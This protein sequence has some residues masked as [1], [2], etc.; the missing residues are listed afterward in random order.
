[1]TNSVRISDINLRINTQNI[2]TTTDIGELRKEIEKV[3]EYNTELDKTIINSNTLSQTKLTELRKHLGTFT[4][5]FEDKIALTKKELNDKHHNIKNLLFDQNDKFKLV[6][7]VEL[8][9]RIK[10]T[11]E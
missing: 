9:E 4:T 3:V 8:D 7:V 6:K 5:M 2:K 1:M 11:K 10:D